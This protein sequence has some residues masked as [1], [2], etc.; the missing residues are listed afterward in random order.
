M[1]GRFLYGNLWEAFKEKRK[2][3]HFRPSPRKVPNLIIIFFE[4]FSKIK[5]KLK[6]SK[7]ATLINAGPIAHFF[8]FFGFA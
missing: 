2:K 6:C 3:F 8:V 4:G 5:N 7:V 1:A